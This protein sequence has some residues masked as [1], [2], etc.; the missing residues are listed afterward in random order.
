MKNQA[1]KNPIGYVVVCK[2]D[3]VIIEFKTTPKKKPQIYAHAQPAINA[4]K[5]LRNEVMVG[6]QDVGEWVAMT[7]WK[8][9]EACSR[10]WEMTKG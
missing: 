10:E 3:G 9:A 2:R 4:V 6:G 7:T 8:L 5:R 1:I